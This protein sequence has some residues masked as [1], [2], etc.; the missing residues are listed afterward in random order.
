MYSPDSNA[1]ALML[2]CCALPNDIAPSRSISLYTLAGLVAEY[3]AEGCLIAMRTSSGEMVAEVAHRDSALEASARERFLGPGSGDG[4]RFLR[5]AVASGSP[6][7]IPATESWMG[8]A[9]GVTRT[10]LRLRTARG[11]SW[12]AVPMKCNGVLIGGVQLLHSG[13]GIKDAMSDVNRTIALGKRLGCVLAQWHDAEMPES[14]RSRDEMLALVAHDL[15][16]PLNV[17]K[18]G[19][20]LMLERLPTDEGFQRRWLGA[21]IMAAD[22]MNQILNDLVEVSRLEAG[23]PAIRSERTRLDS[24]LRNALQ[25]YSFQAEQKGIRLELEDVAPEAYVIVDV[26]AVQRVLSN[27]LDNALRFTPAGGAIRIR[28]NRQDG[29]FQIEVADTGSGIQ[30]EHLPHIF[31]RFYQ[32]KSSHRAGAGLGLA[33]AKGIVEAHGGSIWARSTPG[34]GTTFYFTLR[35]TD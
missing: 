35:A 28:A 24:L 10:P 34:A 22:R 18:M 26:E 5:S 21:T 25:L 32:A 2:D 27:L 3:H 7:V 29:D 13:T 16:N 8:A 17:I 6:V 33:I 4:L 14:A 23:Q 31:D 1:A 19:A 30:P 20:E 15:R 11:S 12:V 9:A